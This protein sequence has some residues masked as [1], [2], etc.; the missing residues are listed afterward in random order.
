MKYTGRN[1]DK[2]SNYRYE[3]SDEC[4]DLVILEKE[5]FCSFV[6]LMSDEDVLSIFFEKRF[7]EPFSKNIIIEECSDY[8]TKSSDDGGDKWID[9]ASYCRYSCG[10]HHE[11]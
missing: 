10:Y 9:I 2:M 3:S 8:R 11:F 5:I 6:F 4:I 1:R 7:P